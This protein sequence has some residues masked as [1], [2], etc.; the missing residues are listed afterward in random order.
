MAIDNRE[1]YNEFL[2]LINLFS[3]ELI[4]LRTL[5]DRSRSFLGDELLAQ[6]K[7]ILGWDAS[8]DENIAPN[9]LGVHVVGQ[10]AGLERPS[11]ETLSIQNGPSYRRLPA[12]VRYINYVMLY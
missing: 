6:F 5:V 3:Q 8:W 12:S 7:N 9:G 11:K 4:D 2:K 10:P 1:V